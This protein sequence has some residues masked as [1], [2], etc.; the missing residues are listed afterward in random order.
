MAEPTIRTIKQLF[1]I[2]G[3]R[4]AFPNCQHPMAVV[5]STG[6]VTGKI[7]HIQGNKPG[8]TR[9]DPAQ[10]EADRQSFEN[11]ILLCGFHHD[12][13]DGDDS[14]YAV[15][16]LR[17][18]KRRHESTATASAPISDRMAR[19]ALLMAAG[20]GSMVAITSIARDVGDFIST[21][22]DAFRDAAGSAAPKPPARSQELEVIGAER[23][24]EILDALRYG[25]KGQVM[26]ILGLEPFHGALVSLAGL[27]E[28]GGWRVGGEMDLKP[29]V[30][31]PPYS[32][33]LFCM[34][35][36]SQV[37]NARQTI[38]HVF[39]KL[40]F[41]YDQNAELFRRKHSKAP[42]RLGVV[43]GHTGLTNT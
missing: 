20:A 11:L 36:P 26:Y 32:I 43:V 8:A 22:V 14:A 17:D 39:E 9:Y 2:S 35:N 38:G 30:Q 28:K 27:F 29:G 18:M 34:S 6:T 40:G 37:S 15:E 7:C 41:T 16:Q 3:N 4:C 33:M 5:E 13:I 10:S 12:V 1:A 19:D 21:I 23:I 24:Q 42:M 31:R 25:P